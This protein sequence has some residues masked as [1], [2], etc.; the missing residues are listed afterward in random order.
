MNLIAKQQF[1]VVP[2]GSSQ[3]YQVQLT[4]GDYEPWLMK[5][6][7]IRELQV[8]IL[9]ILYLNKDFHYLL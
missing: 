5:G 4:S 9:I 2:L 7:F 8:T 1:S 3:E 6:G